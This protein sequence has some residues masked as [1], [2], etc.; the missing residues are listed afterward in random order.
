MSPRTPGG[1]TGTAGTAGRAPGAAHRRLLG[2]HR[3]RKTQTDQLCSHVQALRG[4]HDMGQQGTWDMG[5]QEWRRG[6]GS[7]GQQRQGMAG[8]GTGPARGQGTVGRESPAQGASGNGG[9]WGEGT[10][11]THLAVEQDWGHWGHTGDTGTHLS[12]AQGL[13]D[14]GHWGHW[15]HTCPWCWV[16]SCT[17]G[18]GHRDIGDT[19]GTAGD[20]GTHLSVALR[21]EPHAGPRARPGRAVAADP[22]HQRAPLSAVS[23]PVKLVQSRLRPGVTC[24]DSGDGTEGTVGT[25]RGCNW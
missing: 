16:K 10:L 6:T 22:R 1:D 11:G 2:G 8:M 13:Q 14:W 4:H 17:L 19:Q 20:T 9:N 5:Q 15:G 21:E 23:Q 18:R 25:P 3:N 7:E 12:V 24:G